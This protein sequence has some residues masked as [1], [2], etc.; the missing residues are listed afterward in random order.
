MSRKSTPQ[1]LTLVDTPLVGEERSY[2][3]SP[4]PKTSASLKSPKSPKSPFRFSSKKSPGEPP[5]MQPADTQQT[6]RD[7]PSSKTSPSLTTP[8]A[9]TLESSGGLD[10][11]KEERERSS[12]SGIFSNY[13]AS[14]SSNRLQPDNS[15]PDSYESMSRDTERPPMIR[16]VSSQESNADK[17]TERSLT[18]KP[19]GGPAIS[20]TS[21]AST[22]SPAST[23]TSAMNTKKNKPKPFSILRRTNSTRDEQSP[24]EPAAENLQVPERPNHF[25]SLKTAPLRSDNEKSF[26]DMMNSSIR[27]RSED[28]QPATSREHPAPKDVREYGRTTTSSFSNSFREGTFL[29]NLKSS[30]T[31]GAGAISKGLFGKSTRSA[32]TSEIGHGGDDNNYQFK[33]LNL[34]L[35][36]QTRLTRISKRL[37]D[38]KDKTEYWMP[39]FPWRAIDY[40]NY[41]GSEVEGLYRIPGS[42]TEVRLWQKKFDK[43]IDID[44]FA[45]QDLYDINIIGSML[46]KWFRQLPDEVLPKAIQDRIHVKYKEAE[47]VPQDFVDELS[48]LPPFNYYLLF[49]ITCHLSLLLIHSEKTKMNF[50]NLCICFQPC[51]KMD[52]TSFRFLVCHWRDCWKG[53]KREAEFLEQ[54]YLY[55]EKPPGS[56]GHSSIAV[57][58]HD[59]R[60]VSSSD[61]SKPSSVSIDNYG[62]KVQSKKQATQS[63]SHANVNTVQAPLSPVHERTPPRSNDMRPLSPIKPL[64]PIGL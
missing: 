5:S 26:R 9:Q 54:E 56:A 39:A 62:Q 60:N 17:R 33:V 37:E 51:M 15:K 11:E 63:H 55:L 41:K 7:L 35:V 8:Y 57:E 10:Q 21:L 22:E 52:V 58:S 4:S 50:S 14:K 44:L 64:S 43:E 46:K 30:A 45:E 18:R 28:R 1:P 59:E 19:V 23:P 32:S 13:K 29:N 61:S 38:S 20:D 2:I 53:C 27:Q 42:E 24:V 47:T 16:K 12:R 49:A 40:L 36:E 6:Q 34:P 25:H 48:N 31:K 3:H